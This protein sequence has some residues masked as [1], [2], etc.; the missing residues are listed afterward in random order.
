M[1]TTEHLSVDAIDH[2]LRAAVRAPSPHNTQPWLFLVRPDHVD[3]WLDRDRVLAVADSTA[4]EARISC[5]AALYNLW[6]DLTAAGRATTVQLMPDHAASDLLARVWVAGRRRPRPDEIELATVIHRRTSN[7]RPFLDRAVPMA[8]RSALNRAAAAEDGT[9]VWLD[10]PGESSA[11]ADLLRRAEASQGDDPRFQSELRRWVSGGVERDDGVSDLA[12]PMHPGRDEVLALRD[13]HGESTVERQYERDPQIAVLASRG[14]TAIDHLR[15]GQALQRILLTA[16]LG[17][18][19]TSFISQPIEVPT[20]R[21]AVR[22]LLG[23]RL[24]PQAALRVGY[25][26]PTQTTRR[27]PVADVITVP[28]QPAR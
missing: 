21:H 25:G 8:A 13:Y 24:H 9:L 10:G 11:Y 28:P 20:G 6:L 15:A 12:A 17:G 14:D 4:R 22:A 5:G 1:S 16:T 18:L 23:G 27:R 26:D 3:V 2:A 19:S 7:R